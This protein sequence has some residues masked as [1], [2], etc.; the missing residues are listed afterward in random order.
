MTQSIREKAQSIAEC[1][2]RW[3]GLKVEVVISHL[4]EK[5]LKIS[6]RYGKFELVLLPRPL[7]GRI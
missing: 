6:Q 4:Q 3:R 1:Q 7:W 5:P 2:R